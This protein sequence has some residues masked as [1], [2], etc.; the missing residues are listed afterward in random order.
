MSPTP[1]I[2]GLDVGTTHAK[3][4]A[5]AGDGVAWAMAA[6]ELPLLQGGPGRA[7]Q[8]PEVVVEASLA[9]LAEA[10][11]AAKA[12]GGEVAG[13]C[14]GTA[15]HGLVGLDG[16]G[17]PMTP[18]LTWA[19]Q[20]A[21]AKAQ[22]VRRSIAGPALAR[23]TGAPLHAMTPLFKLI[24]FREEE[25]E[26]FARVAHWT[27]PKSLLLGRLV[28]TYA[29]DPSVAGA[30]GL[31]NLQRSDWDDEALALAGVRRE[32]LPALVP[33]TQ[34]LGGLRRDVAARLGVAE[35]APVVAGA[36]DGAFANL[37]AGAMGPGVAACTV[38]TSGAV[39]ITVNQPLSDPAGR[40]FC[41]PLA[42]GWWV[43][44]GAV[45]DGGVTLRWLRD[46]LFV[47]L[48]H[49]GEDAYEALAALAAEVPE[50]A[51]GLWFLPGLT[52]ERAPQRTPSARGVLFG[53]SLA[54][55]RG[56][57]VRAVMEGVMLQL[58]GV[59]RM[60]GAAGLP[61]SEVRVNGGAMRS[62]L[63]RRIMADAFG[64]RLTLTSTEEASLFGA[65]LLGMVALGWKASLPEAAKLVAVTGREEPSPGAAE[66]APRRLAEFER[67]LHAVD[68]L[69][70]K[71]E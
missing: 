55:R 44:G 68:P 1:L 67:L 3:A 35:G 36:S 52:G 57:V 6:R 8:D 22:R 62:P 5:F 21:E 59:V 58:A 28:G 32:T 46:A 15:M 49:S 20:R 54:H 63:W 10:I 70:E 12:R 24:W 11:G 71:A 14:V 45:N 18:L 2:V 33:G 25:P 13:L 34:V 60:L 30:T 19:D 42:P 66:N 40:L 38:G 48:A 16:A 26:L 56:H 61:V 53:L 4:A 39:R 69:F 65:A 29:V 50:G 43:A 64:L 27:S 47:D 37:G 9:A 17:R 41:Y 23:R 31:F 7:E 51:E